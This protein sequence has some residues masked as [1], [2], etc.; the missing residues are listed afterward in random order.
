[1]YNNKNSFAYQSAH[2]FLARVVVVGAVFL[3]GLIIARL[4][5]PDGKGIVSLFQALTAIVLPLAEL[6]I[7]QS[8]AFFIGKKEYPE[9]DIYSNMQG[10]YSTASITSVVLLCIMYWNLGYFQKYNFFVCIPFIL[11]AP[12]TLFE[13]Y[14][15]GVFIGNKMVDKINYAALADRCSTVFLL[16]IFIWFL[17]LGILGVGISYLAGKLFGFAV[18][19]YWLIRRISFSPAFNVSLWKGLIGKGV[20]FAVALFVIQINYRLNTILLGYFKDAG[21][22]GIFSIGVNFAEVLKE[23]PL[24]LGLVLFSR[25]ANWN[26][27]SAKESINKVMVLARILLFLMVFISIIL[28]I[29]VYFLI[30]FLY[31]QEFTPSVTVTLFLLP[32]IV[33]L[34][35]FLILN[36]FMAGQGRPDIA[37]KVFI[38]AILIN[39]FIGFWIIPLWNANGAAIASSASY[40]CAAIF[41]VFIFCKMYNVPAKDVLILQPSDILRIKSYCKNNKQLNEHFT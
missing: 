12:F 41:Y 4:L 1:M 18:I 11:I 8:T 22:V 10:I 23:I 28:G 26:A 5:G 34:S 3:S 38:P 17:K 35:V 27:D 25:S 37:I 13:S 21:N 32:G 16:V 33:M 24:A 9:S 30:P 2:T 36:L 6:G 19:F 20:V 7:R 40:C 14:H 29:A 15:N 31:G 39:L